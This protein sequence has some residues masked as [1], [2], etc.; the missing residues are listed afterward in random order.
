MQRMRRNSLGRPREFLAPPHHH[1]RRTVSP[2][3]RLGGGCPPFA[4]SSSSSSSRLN[5]AAARACFRASNTSTVFASDFARIA[6]ISSGKSLS[7]ARSL[8]LPLRVLDLVPGIR[9]LRQPLDSFCFS[10][11]ARVAAALLPHTHGPAT[12]RQTYAVKD[13][14]RGRLGR[15]RSRHWRRYA[16]AELRHVSRT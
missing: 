11:P 8:S 14:H 10:C 7:N 16:E 6:L 1:H 12:A 2:I 3:R 15:Q 4:A 5:F 13:A 9:G